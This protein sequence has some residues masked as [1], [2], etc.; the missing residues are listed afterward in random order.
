M[1]G[2]AFL[3]AT[4]D[5]GLFV[6]QGR[7]S[8]PDAGRFQSFPRAAWQTEI[9]LAPTIPLRGIEWIFDVHGVGVNPLETAAGRASLCDLLR[10]HRVMIESVCADYFM[11]RPLVDGHTPQEAS[12]TTLRWLMNT[13]GE[14]SIRRIVLPFVDASRITDERA[15][16]A[17]LDVLHG[18][19]PDAEAAG[20]ELHLE[21]DLSPVVFRDLLRDIQHPLVKVNYDSGNSAALGYRS[22]DEFAAYGERI[23]SI[24]IKDRVLGGGTVPLGY[25][26]ADFA[27]LRS[28]IIDS[29]FAGGFVLQVARGMPGDEVPWLTDVNVQVCRWLRGEAE[30]TTR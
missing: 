16:A 29:D 21:T 18:V 24:H 1:R 4:A 25:G 7:L 17:T 12:V 8:A 23:G 14:M 10:A 30:I 13:C 22:A 6:M 27:M 3:E 15:A 19:L 5:A 20:V 28:A 2:S 26:Q 11:D 9:A